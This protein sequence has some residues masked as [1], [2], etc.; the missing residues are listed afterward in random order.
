MGDI[1]TCGGSA[2]APS[3]QGPL[4]GAALFILQG[5][6][7]FAMHAG[8]FRKA[9]RPGEHPA[10]KAT[11]L[12]YRPGE[13]QPDVRDFAREPRL[14]EVE[15]AIGGRPEAVAGFLSIEHAGVIRRCVALAD[16]D[17]KEKNAPLNVTATLLWDSALRKDFGITLMRAEGRADALFGTVAVLFLHGEASANAV[18]AERLRLPGS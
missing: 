18:T 13:R 7:P 3:L 8:D 4:S 12:L 9:G 5:R 14:D 2:A 10:V 15:R 6:P 11:L 1:V 17:A 16:R